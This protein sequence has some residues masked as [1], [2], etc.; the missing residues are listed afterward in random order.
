LSRTHAPDT[1]LV[2]RQVDFIVSGRAKRGIRARPDRGSVGSRSNI[3][4]VGAPLPV[5]VA[6]AV[7]LAV[8]IVRFKRTA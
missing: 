4:H 2:S 3:E 7:M 8:A 6:D 5:A 1:V